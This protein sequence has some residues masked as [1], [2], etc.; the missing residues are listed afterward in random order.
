MHH[1]PDK[2]KSLIVLRYLWQMWS[3]FNN[4]FTL[5]FSYKLRKSCV[6]TI[7]PHLK[8]VT[9]LPCEIWMFNFATFYSC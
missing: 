9:T 3:D 6:Q 1:V 2:K 7:P 5:A 8:S 4:S